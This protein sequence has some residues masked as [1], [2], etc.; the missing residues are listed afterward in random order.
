MLKQIP[1]LLAGIAIGIGG[2]LLFAA[3]RASITPPAA[4]PPPLSVTLY[5]FR[6]Q[7][8]SMAAYH[9][10]IAWQHADQRAIVQS[11]ERERMYVEAVFRDSIHDPDG[12]YW[13]AVNSPGGQPY[14]NSPLRVD[15]IHAGFMR[16]IL[17]P[18]SRLTLQTEY[19]LIPGFLQQSIAT[20][21]PPQ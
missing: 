5:H 15:S 10:W 8:D 4:A 6:L 7:K 12:I 20:H 21:H 9:D 11:L 14:Q 2:S 3:H 1:G 13:L 19:Y 17:V 18:G 16:R